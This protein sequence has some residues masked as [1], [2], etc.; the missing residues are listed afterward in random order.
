MHPL[1]QQSVKTNCKHACRTF[2]FIIEKIPL[3]EQTHSEPLDRS[4]RSQL[5]L[6]YGYLGCGSVWGIGD[7]VGRKCL[8][9]SS[10]Y[11]HG[12]ENPGLFTWL[13][14]DDHAF[15]QRTHPVKVCRFVQIW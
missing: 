14:G 9:H 10:G 8:C 12:P 15:P 3:S 5:G 11:A 2:N 7:S 4:F 13:D 6:L 1:C